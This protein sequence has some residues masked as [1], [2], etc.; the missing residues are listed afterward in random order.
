[1]AGSAFIQL[2]KHV[3][4]LAFGPVGLSMP[5]WVFYDCAV[6][7][8]A[9]FG[10]ARRARHLESWARRALAV[11]NN[12]DGLVPVSIFICIPTVARTAALVYTLCSVNQIAPGAAPPRGCGASPS[13]R[14]S[15]GLWPAREMHGHSCSGARSQLGL[16]AG[17]GP[18][19]T[20]SPPGPRPTTTPRPAT[21]RVAADAAM[22]SSACSAATSLGAEGIDALRRRRRHLGDLRRC[23]SQIEGG[24]RRSPWPARPRSAAPTPASR[25]RSAPA[26]DA[27]FTSQ[28]E[29][30]LHPAV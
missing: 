18:L 7:P 3:D 15:P 30:R 2:V 24:H 28:P 13:P 8:G 26:T 23:K 6:M 11:P 9:V 17:L 20:R 14:A 1:V 27:P 12:Y 4:E 25:S 19:R 5:A 29:R 10:F 16:F 21:F 22:P